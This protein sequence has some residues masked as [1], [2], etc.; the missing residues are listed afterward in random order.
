MQQS[1]PSSTDGAPRAG[2][3][4]GR[5]CGAG[6]EKLLLRMVGYGRHHICSLQCLSRGVVNIPHHCLF[7]ED[8]VHVRSN[9]QSNPESQVFSVSGE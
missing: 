4:L 7:K 8:G 9:G 1:I 3:V 2:G 5:G 6:A